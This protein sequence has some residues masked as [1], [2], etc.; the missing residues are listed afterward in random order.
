MIPKYARKY[1]KVYEWI[2]L[3]DILEIKK[4]GG[5][6]LMVKYARIRH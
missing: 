6:L 4:Q 1:K 2:Y 3:S 5:I